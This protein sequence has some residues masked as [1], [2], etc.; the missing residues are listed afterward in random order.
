MLQKIDKNK[1]ILQTDMLSDGYYL[2][3]MQT[4]LRLIASYDKD[5]IHSD[6]IELVCTFLGDLIQDDIQID[7]SKEPK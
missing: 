3:L 1:Y 6:D 4:M 2:S 7:F 5:Y